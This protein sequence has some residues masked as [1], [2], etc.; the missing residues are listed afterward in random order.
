MPG[1]VAT[2]LEHMQA[3]VAAAA[4]N[5]AALLLFSGGATRASA[6]PLSEAVSY[7]AVA[8]A[9]GW[10]NEPGVR[11][12]A[13]TEEH[14]RDSYEN[15]LFSLCRFHELTGAWP[16]NV[17]VVGYEF[18]RARFEQLHRAAVAFPAARFAY[19]GTPAA[20]PRAEEGE[21]LAAAAFQAEPFG[22]GAA[23]SAK[24]H[25]RDPF[26]R[27]VPYVARCAALA[28]LLRHCG[29][30]PF[31]GALPWREGAAALSLRA[32]EGDFIAAAAAL[33]TTRRRA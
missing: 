28:P 2:F 13:Y 5:P 22:C 21:A 6:G 17:T 24:R 26:A 9:Q 1:Q 7:W 16:R 18:K 15:L 4:A 14:A 3:G 32:A 11:D 29:P 30:E 19:V 27:G 8:N 10:F 20:T 31:R 33:D 25:L 23:L 12:R